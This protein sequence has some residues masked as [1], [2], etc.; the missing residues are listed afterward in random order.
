MACSLVVAFLLPL[1]LH[2]NINADGAVY[3]EY[4]GYDDGRQYHDHVA[5]Y[6]ILFIIF[7]PFFC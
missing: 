2:E 6:E 5:V 3:A 7:P 4:D 1:I